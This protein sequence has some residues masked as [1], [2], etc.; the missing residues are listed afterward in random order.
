MWVIT[1]IVILPHEDFG[2]NLDQSIINYINQKW[3]KILGRFNKGR[4]CQGNAIPFL[5]KLIG[6]LGKENVV[7]KIYMDIRFTTK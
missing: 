5:A 7:A 4:S 1:D 2:T 3:N 6:F